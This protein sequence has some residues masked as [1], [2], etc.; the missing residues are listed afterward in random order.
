MPSLQSSEEMWEKTVGISACNNYDAASVKDS[1]RDVLQKCGGI[2][3]RIENGARVLIKPNMLAPALSKEAVTTHPTIIASLIEVVQEMG[4]VAYVGDSPMRGTLDEVAQISGIKEA[5]TQAGASL[6]SLEEEKEVFIDNKYTTGTFTLSAEAMEMD[7]IINAAKL[8]THTLTGL[9]AAV[10]NFYGVIPGKHK[11]YYHVRHPL[12]SDFANFLLGL[13]FSMPPSLSV[14]DAIVAMEGMGPRSGRP[15]PCGAIFASPDAVALDAAC[16]KFTSHNVAEVS[17]LEAAVKQGYLK[18]DFSDVKINGPIEELKLQDFDK[19]AGGKGWSFL[20]RY[21]PVFI[22]NLR[23]RKRPWPYVNE[24]CV[25]CNTCIDSCP[26]ECI[27]ANSKDTPSL[28]IDHS[29]CIRCYCCQEACPYGA[30]SLR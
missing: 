1:L 9:T 22:N 13:Y 19:G 18:S 27:E 14:V 29:R 3:H 23:E 8:K 15:R 30:I 6:L 24:V 2:E 26:V 7:L 21:L 5:V 17:V 20:W 28:F 25:G 16:A 12:L 11:K 4:G 10:K